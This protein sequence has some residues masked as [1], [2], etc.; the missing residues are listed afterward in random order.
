[1]TKIE[2]KPVL[3]SDTKIL[4]ED[5]SLTAGIY[6]FNMALEKVFLHHKEVWSSFISILYF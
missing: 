2:Y 3:N 6:S 4:L 1:M 5:P